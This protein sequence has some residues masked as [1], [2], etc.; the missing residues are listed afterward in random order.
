MKYGELNL[1]QIEALVNKLGGMDA[2]RNILSGVVEITTK[3]I[4]YIVAVFTAMVDETVSVEDAVK[5]GK[6]DW[7]NDNITS[8]NFP[9]ITGGQKADKEVTIFHFNKTM[10]SEAVIAEMD[11]AG[12]KPANIWA[13]IGLAVKE[14]DLQRKFP[15][16]A[17]GSVCELGGYRRVPYLYEGSSERNLGLLYFDDGWDDRYRFL[18]VRK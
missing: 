9:K 15:I 5:T 4:S 1:G 3:V 10:T 13:L 2:V 14:P 7:S 16:V 18:A 12:Y 11:K 6:F 17:L 8:A